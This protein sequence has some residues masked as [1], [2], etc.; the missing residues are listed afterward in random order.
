MRNS[1]FASFE[2]LDRLEEGSGGLRQGRGNDE[3][4]AGG[5][6]AHRRRKR[7]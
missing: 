5:S 7:T 2:G 3:G 6:G 1:E 4:V